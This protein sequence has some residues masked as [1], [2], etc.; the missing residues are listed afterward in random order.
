MTPAI[1]HRDARQIHRLIA[2]WRKKTGIKKRGVA[3]AFW[4]G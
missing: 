1:N 3:A 2:Q 4:I